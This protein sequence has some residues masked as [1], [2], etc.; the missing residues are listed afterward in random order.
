MSVQNSRD[1]I[2]NM[3]KGYGCREGNIVFSDACVLIPVC[4]NESYTVSHIITE[5][6]VDYI[7]RNGAD[8]YDKV[9]LISEFLPIYS[10]K[11]SMSESKYDYI[12]IGRDDSCNPRTAFL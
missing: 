3:L 12:R 8:A 6:K 4:K 11:K 5:A 7:A 2:V 9:E 10:I 1:D